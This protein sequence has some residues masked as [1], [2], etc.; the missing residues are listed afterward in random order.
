MAAFSRN[1][2]FTLRR[3]YLAARNEVIAWTRALE[4]LDSVGGLGAVGG[5]AQDPVGLD[6]L[7]AALSNARADAVASLADAEAR[8]IAADKRAPR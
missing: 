6:H 2:L 5:V 4:G 8:I 3:E 1:T 7:R